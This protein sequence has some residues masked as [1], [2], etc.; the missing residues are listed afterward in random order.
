MNLQRAKE[1]SY[2]FCE[3]HG[4]GRKKKKKRRRRRRASNI[5]HAYP[6]PSTSKHILALDIAYHLSYTAS[7]NLHERI[8]EYLAMEYP[9]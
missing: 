6:Y 7:S 4:L 5:A 1:Q 8:L 9:Y 2:Q 3:G